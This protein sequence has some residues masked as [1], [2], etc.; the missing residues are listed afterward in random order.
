MS[1]V[2]IAVGDWKAIVLDR[3]PKGTH[4]AITRLVVHYRFV[5]AHTGT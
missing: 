1:S 4:A 5:Q 3:T 2:T